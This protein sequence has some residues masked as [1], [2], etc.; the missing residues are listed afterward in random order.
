M[1]FTIQLYLYF[2]IAQ[3]KL[4]ATSKN[5]DW[6]LKKVAIVTAQSEFSFEIMHFLNLFKDY[7]ISKKSLITLTTF[8]KMQNGYHKK[9][10]LN[11]SLQV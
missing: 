4:G 9:L 1:P 8:S 10:P 6:L 5:F 3:F 7:N 2:L 11:H